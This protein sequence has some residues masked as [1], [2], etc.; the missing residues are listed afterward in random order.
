MPRFEPSA[1]V[2]VR[3]SDCLCPDTP[4]ADGD[5][6]TLYDRLPV[7]AGT[8]ATR[9]LVNRKPSQD[10]EEAILRA[11]LPHIIID[12]TI[13]DHETGQPLEITPD[14]V[15]E[16]LP[17]THGGYEVAKAAADRYLDAVVTPFLSRVLPKPTDKSSPTTQ[18]ASTSASP[19]SSTKRRKPSAS[20]SDAT[21]DGQP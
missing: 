10:P 7:D 15:A 16:A 9:A 3:V 21:S 20:S 14:N 17:W 12:W 11:I 6:V 2:R 19:S 4:H 13:L 18:T 1:P 8:A 5:F